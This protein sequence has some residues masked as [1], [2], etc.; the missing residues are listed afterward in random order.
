MQCLQPQ[1]GW[2]NKKTG[3]LA[4]YGKRPPEQ[5]SDDY[6]YIPLPC[7][8]CL[9]CRANYAKGL[10]LRCQLESL[11]HT[12]SCFTTLTYDEA[13]LPATLDARHY[14]LWL[15]QLR[16]AAT[17]GLRKITRGKRTT[18]PLRYFLSGEYGETNLRP[19]FHAIIWGLHHT[20]QRIQNAWPHGHAHTV[21]VTPEAISYVAGYTSKKLNDA[22]HAAH[23]RVNPDTGEVYTWVPP[24]TKWSQGLGG[25]T[26]Q[27]NPA[28]WKHYAV[29]DGH[30]M[31]VPRYLHN[32]WLAQA[33]ETEIQKLK[34]QK[35]ERNKD[36]K[37]TQYD[38][39]SLAIISERTREI[40]ADKR[41]L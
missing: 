10:A 38:L 24:F 28:S 16:R 1:H 14:V 40:N 41:K 7:N 12:Q 9:P 3:G 37:L 34:H 30:Q 17:E 18:Y 27:L 31:Q 2:Q 39:N 8:K 4:S 21:V 11:D 19:H 33:T 23:E 32:I 22:A 5:R 35:M 20:D 29:K 25:K 15:K 13:H 6:Q 36:K 26:A